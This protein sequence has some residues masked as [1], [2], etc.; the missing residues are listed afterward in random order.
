MNTNNIKTQW[1]LKVTKGNLKISNLL[2]LRYIFCLQP[3]LLKTFQECQHYEDTILKVIQGRKGNLYAK[4]ILAHSFDFDKR[5][6][7]C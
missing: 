3:N 7:E 6:Y 4:T 1:S 5:F 2:F